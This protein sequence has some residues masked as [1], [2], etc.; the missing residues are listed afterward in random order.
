MEKTHSENLMSINLLL[1]VTAWVADR[2]TQRATERGRKDIWRWKIAHISFFLYFIR[3]N[4]I[5]ALSVIDLP[6]HHLLYVLIKLSQTHMTHMCG[7]QFHRLSSENFCACASMCAY[8]CTF[9]TGYGLAGLKPDRKL[10]HHS[11]TTEKKNYQV[12]WFS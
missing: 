7:L 4:L 11:P 5:N 3:S 1:C 10:Y 9:N 6:H 2:K 12:N 8:V